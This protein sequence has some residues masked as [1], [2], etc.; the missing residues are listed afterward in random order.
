MVKDKIWLWARELKASVE[1]LYRVTHDS[2]I[3]DC[4][5]YLAHAVHEENIEELYCSTVVTLYNIMLK[6]EDWDGKISAELIGYVISQCECILTALRTRKVQILDNKVREYIEDLE[7]RIAYMQDQPA[8][9]DLPEQ[10]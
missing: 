10:V 1:C 5:D 4:S 2:D 7:G 8:W 6:R 3:M 9:H